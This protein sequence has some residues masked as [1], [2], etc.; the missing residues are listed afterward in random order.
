MTEADHSRGPAI[1]AIVAWLQD[2][3]RP[4]RRPE[5]V[6]ADLGARLLAAGVPLHRVALFVRTLHPNVMGR[7]FVWRPEAPVEIS[8]GSYD[9]LTSDTYRQSPVRPVQET[10]RTFRRR[11]ADPD[12]PRDFVILDELRAE[13]VSDY[14]IQPLEFSDG[15]VHAISWTTCR[16][17]GFSDAD[18][19][20][21]EAIRPPLARLTEAYALRRV[22]ATLLATYVGRSTGQRILEGR[23]RRGDIEHI[24][25]VILLADLRGFTRLSDTLPADRVIELLN[26]W[27][28]AL[29][30]AIEQA[31]GEVLKFMGDGVLAIFPVAAEPAAACSSALAAVGAA[32]E[33]L[34]AFNAGLRAGGQAELRYGMALH[35]GEVLYGNIGSSTRLDFTTI[36]PA[37]NL[38][39]RL[40]TL[41]RDLGRDLLVSA[42]FA[43]HCPDAVTRL[44]RFELRGF[45]APV[46]VFAPAPDEPAAGGR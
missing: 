9:F 2:G 10:G 12:C 5:D 22:L 7:R 41:A 37:V 31:G 43:A 4:L 38:T 13:G 34:A 14:L 42:A 20:A 17:G 40:E 36:G 30:P 23:V 33:A 32:R 15:Q 11:I 46:E 27:F 3:A 25:A 1:G 18:L 21:L 8:E 28:D 19:A 6:M 35:R 29:V 24:Q 16:P 26:G 44:G 45:R 39:A